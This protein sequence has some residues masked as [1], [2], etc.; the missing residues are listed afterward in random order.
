MGSSPVNK[1]VI[2][3]MFIVPASSEFSFL[4]H[5]KIVNSTFECISV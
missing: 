4:I 2:A 1:E 3:W 5:A